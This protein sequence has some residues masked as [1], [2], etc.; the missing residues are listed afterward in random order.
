M[1]NTIIMISAGMKRPKKDF[2]PLNGLNLYL[3]YGLLGLGTILSDKGYDLKI[4]Q[5]DYK[6]IEEILLEIKLCNIEIH[7]LKYP[8]FISAPS[9]FA[10]SWIK[11]LIDS[12]K[13]ISNAKV[14]L[15]GRWVVDNNIGWLKEQLAKV[16]LFVKGYG[17]KYIEECL[18][19]NNWKKLDEDCCQDVKVFEKLNYTNLFNF[20]IYQPCIEI[21]RGCGRGCEFC[22]ENKIK[23]LD[24][25]AP[26][27][28]IQ[29]AKNIAN[30]YGCDTLNFYFQAS[31]FN[32]TQ[33]WTDT[34]CRLYQE[35]NMHFNWRF[36]T[37]VDSLNKNTL[38]T[39][40]KAGLKVID[41]GFESASKIQLLNMKKTNNVEEYLK[42]A[43]ELLEEAYKNEIWIKLNILLY[44]GETMDTINETLQWLYDKKKYIKGI[45][46]NPLSVN[47]LIVYKNGD[48][49][50]DFIKHVELLSGIKV[51]INSL[52]EKGYVFT[53]LSRD[54]NSEYAEKMSLSISRN[55]MSI[56]DYY[57]L[58]AICY[59]SR[60]MGFENLE[61][62]IN[63]GKYKSAD[64][65][66]NMS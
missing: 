26:K 3:N 15:G 22:L 6:S 43:Q 60:N 53:D 18:D 2:N 49:T 13:R 45:S 52:E 29:E 14:V 9:I 28:I 33:I 4:F 65:P 10:L 64:L 32:P 66:F 57:D 44:P 40:A 54:I 1:N 31:I 24:N 55:F 38:E 21:S 47:P 63:T 37:R 20:R 5:G 58:K 27:E 62:I 7:D 59:Y 48:F 61:K 12:I 8:I 50:Y 41:L 35:N 39:L 16:D 46:V 23:A 19:E 11:E 42:K 34:F 25:K 56:S 36:E 30:V 17:E 51:D